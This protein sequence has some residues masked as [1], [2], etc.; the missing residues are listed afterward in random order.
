MLDNSRH[1]V[2]FG[3][4]A[5]V[6]VGIQD[7]CIVR[8]PVEDGMRPCIQ[9]DDGTTELTASLPERGIE[10]I[11]PTTDIRVARTVSG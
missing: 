4:K 10:A 9:W 8:F 2:G 1:I 7:G 6:A 5:I 11:T 3:E